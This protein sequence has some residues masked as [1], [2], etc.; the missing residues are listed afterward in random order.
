MNTRQ[1]NT[2][3]HPHGSDAGTRD[4][5]GHIILRLARGTAHDSHDLRQVAQQESLGRVR[6][7][8][9]RNPDL[10]AE[11]LIR[12]ASPETIRQR[13]AA[14]RRHGFA[15]LETLTAYWRLDVRSQDDAER[16]RRELAAMDGEIAVAYH[17]NSVSEAGD[18]VQ[19]AG[20]NPYF[21]DQGFLN[22]A[23]QGIGVRDAWTRIAGKGGAVQ[24]I[25]LESGWILGHHDLPKPQLLYGDD[26]VAYGYA[27]GDHGAAAMGIVGAVNNKIG[28]I[29]VVAEALT[30]NAVSHYDAAKND[31]LHVADAIGAALEQLQAGDVLLLEVQRTQNGAVLPTEIDS[32]DFH[33]IR[34]ATAHGIIVIEAAGNGDQDL[35]A[36]TD[37][38]GE[39]ELEV[40][41]TG[42]R[43]SG[44]IM[45]GS[46][47]AAVMAD[48]NG[49]CGHKRYYTSNYGSR[50][51]V[52][53]WGERI[54]TAGYGSAAGSPGGLD[55][56]ASNFGQTSGASAIIAGAAALVQSWCMSEHG[57]PLSA[58]ELRDLLSNPDNGTAQVFMANDR[59]GV[60]PDLD[61]II[62]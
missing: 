21:K 25:D 13:E 26:G 22:A 47:K 23:P 28:V 48:A 5:T 27:K 50:L 49:V 30:L 34:L 2:D 20:A 54:Y 59:I 60:M 56:Y 38:A 15:P 55:S 46:S 33:A 12:H 1:D 37:P 3:N 35:D 61:T 31:G 24:V 18:P 8:L 51:N 40:G 57:A 42:Y 9:D 39:H 6:D 44:A 43:D 4:G 10:D 53:A 32:A 45:V 16:L 11:R 36:W 29:G 17:E 14:A 62:N 52:Y 58:A 19:S 7:F 41:A